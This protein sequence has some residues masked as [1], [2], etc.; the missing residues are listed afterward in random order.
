MRGRKECGERFE[1]IGEDGGEGVSSLGN[2]LTSE[3]LVKK[4]EDTKGMNGFGRL[5]YG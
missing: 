3:S 1:E 2:T 5:E 4:G